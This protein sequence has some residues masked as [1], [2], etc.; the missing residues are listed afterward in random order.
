MESKNSKKVLLAKQSAA[1]TDFCKTI[2]GMV[3]SMHTKNKADADIAQMREQM[4]IA[5]KE[6]PV[7]I[8]LRAGK[9]VWTYREDIAKGEVK[10]FLEND[11]QKEIEGEVADESEKE[12]V[13][14]LIK[15]IKRT[16]RFFNTTEQADMIKKVQNLVKQYA[17]YES[18]KRELEKMDNAEN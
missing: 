3:K 5:I 14:N 13:T 11:Y 15:K 2:Q 7:D 4:T 16:W 1:V 12:Q 8:F 17:I 10:S 9:H 6:V 18:A